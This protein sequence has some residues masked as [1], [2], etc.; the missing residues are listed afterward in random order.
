MRAPVLATILALACAGSLA[1]AQQP[2]PPAPSAAPAQQAVA[3]TPA[4]PPMPASP[5][6]SAAAQVGGRWVEEKPG[7]A[8]RY[9]EGKWITVDYGRPI[10]RGRTNIFGAGA[11]YGK[12]VNGGAP[13][14][15]AGANQTT[16]LKTEVPLVFGTT[17]VP[18][19]EYNV[20]VDLKPGAWTLI[21]S[22][23]PYQQKY[24]PANK[25]DLWGSYNYD[26]KFDLVRVPMQTVDMNLSAE[27]FDIGFLDM[28]QEGGW[29]GMWW[30]KTGAKVAFAVAK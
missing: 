7:A 16:R 30:E 8:P 4:P 13:V 17:T 26:P 22:T 21:L 15:R 12:A 9:R 24:A 2:A 28:T 23:Q 18:A 20:L 3:Q 10:L 19:G 29:L 27:Q 14:W 25:T 11:D 5:R 6:G 1:L